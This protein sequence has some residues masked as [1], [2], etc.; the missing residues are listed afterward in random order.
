MARTSFENL[1]KRLGDLDRERRTIIKQLKATPQY[2]V[3]YLRNQLDAFVKNGQWF[4]R[5]N[6]K[7]ELSYFKLVGFAFDEKG[8]THSDTKKRTMLHVE[9]QWEYYDY[10]TPTKAKANEQIVIS[11]FNDIESQILNG[12]VAAV[13]FNEKSLLKAQLTLRKKQLEDELKT[14]KGEIALIK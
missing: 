10:N 6:K 12:R 3:K 13:D 11:V 1:C 4:S 7:E 9:L 8:I 2:T 14:I 5:K